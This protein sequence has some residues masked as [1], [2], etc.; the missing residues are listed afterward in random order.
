[1]FVPNGARFSDAMTS[2][3]LRFFFFFML[4]AVVF[5]RLA[6]GSVVITRKC[7]CM[8]GTGANWTIYNERARSRII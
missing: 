1:M 2:G 6:K 5:G 3:S 7:V 4:L 8:G